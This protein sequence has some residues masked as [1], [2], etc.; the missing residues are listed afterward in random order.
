[1]LGMSSGRDSSY[2]VMVATRA[3]HP[4]MQKTQCLTHL[5]HTFH[6]KGEGLYPHAR[7]M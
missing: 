4:L 7:T 5:F 1:M 3:G 6:S 2:T